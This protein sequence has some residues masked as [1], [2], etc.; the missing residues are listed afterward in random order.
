MA[1]KLLPLV[2][3][4]ALPEV[5]RLLPGTPASSPHT[6]ELP[7]CWRAAAG[8]PSMQ[9]APMPPGLRLIAFWPLVGELACTCR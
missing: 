8:I 5:P 7:M 3:A 4:L 6:G 1:D 2:Q 9:P